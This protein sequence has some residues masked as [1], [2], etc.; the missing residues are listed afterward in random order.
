MGD[1][2]RLLRAVTPALCRVRL[3]LSFAATL[4]RGRR[5]TLCSLPDV[6]AAFYHALLNEDTWGADHS[7]EEEDDHGRVAVEMGSVRN[8]GRGVDPGVCDTSHGEDRVH[9]ACQHRRSITQPGWCW[10]IRTVTTSWRAGETQSLNMLDE[11]WEQFFVL[12]KMPRIDCTCRVW[13]HQRRTVS[14]GEAVSWSVQ[15]LHWQAHNSRGEK[16][17]RYCGLDKREATR[18]MASMG[19]KHIGKNARDATEELDGAKEVT[20][21]G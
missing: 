7:Q 12:K 5:N 3:V 10:Q 1:T 9:S 20:G 2:S 11:A 13:R 18:R 19:S 4:C 16:V 8:L 17:V 21:T 15:G 6:S 14:P